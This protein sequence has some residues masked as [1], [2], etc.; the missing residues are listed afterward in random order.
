MLAGID[1]SIS[2]RNVCTIRTVM[3]VL[4]TME[5]NSKTMTVLAL[6]RLFTLPHL[7][8]QLSS[9]A[10][11]L[12]GDPLGSVGG[13]FVPGHVDGVSCEEHCSCL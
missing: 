1:S 3:L 4:I 2:G 13:E 7:A 5:R 6:P 10:P 11:S 12:D 9:F 8:G